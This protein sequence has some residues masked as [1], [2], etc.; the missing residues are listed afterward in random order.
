MKFHIFIYEAVEDLVILWVYSYRDRHGDMLIKQ[1]MNTKQIFH[2]T[3]L[4]K[5]FKNIH[6]NRSIILPADI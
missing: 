6:E 5:R 3:L 4:K 1:Q 2:K